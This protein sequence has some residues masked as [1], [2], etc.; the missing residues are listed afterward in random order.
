MAARG[1]E[2]YADNDAQGNTELPRT[3]G[4]QEIRQLVREN[5]GVRSSVRLDPV[6]PAGPAGPADP[7]DS[8]DSTDPA[9]LGGPW[10]TLA[11]LGGPRRTLAAPADLG[12]PGRRSAD[13]GGPR[14]TRPTRRQRLTDRVDPAD[15]A[16]PADP[17][18]GRLSRVCGPSIPANWVEQ[19]DG[20]EPSRPIGAKSFRHH[21]EKCLPTWSF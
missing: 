7:A 10:R 5:V 13:L 15:P 14:R 8:A 12:G 4:Y 2:K 21:Q 3:V 11:D 18:D 16:D 1:W 17:E 6:V 19:A 20:R 9:D